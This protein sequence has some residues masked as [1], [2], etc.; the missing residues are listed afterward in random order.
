MLGGM[1]LAEM[2]LDIKP[3]QVRFIAADCM[4]GHQVQE[5]DWPSQICLRRE[6][7]LVS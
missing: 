5:K 2:K 7:R 3:S 1:G 4:E 6:W